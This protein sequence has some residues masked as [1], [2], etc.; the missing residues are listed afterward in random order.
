M[1]R[2]PTGDTPLVI[3]HTHR[4]LFVELPY[5]ASTAIASE[6]CEN[7]AGVRILYKHAKYVEF[8]R[9]ASAQEKAYFVFSC[10]RN[11]L[12]EAV[13]HYL[14]YMT[15]HDCMF[16]D[17]EKRVRYG[18][19]NAELSTFRW[20]RDEQ[21]VF[22][23]F[24][25]RAYRIPYDNWS[26]LS[27]RQFSFII[28]FENLQGDFD[29]VLERL[30]LTVVRPLPRRNATETKNEEYLTYYTPDVVPYAKRIFGHF[31]REWGY[32]FPPEWGP[33]TPTAREEFDFSMWRRARMLYWRYANRTS[34]KPLRALGV[35]VKARF[36][37]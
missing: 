23:K 28:R 9:N 33:Y 35:R 2:V 36:N 14:R 25:R 26:A 11:P 20:I 24:L 34:S 12:D 30:G 22:S 19:T 37:P 4:Y 15:D 10:I 7:Y 1:W 8:E 6:L 17:P 5:S 16:T 13:S 29:R 18:I 3:S 31:M 21:P 32:V 27:H